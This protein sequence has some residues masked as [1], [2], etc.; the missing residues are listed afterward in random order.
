MRDTSCICTYSR[1]SSHSKD[2][3]WTVCRRAMVPRSSQRPIRRGKSESGCNAWPNKPAGAHSRARAKITT[4][5]IATP[6]RTG[7]LLQA[8]ARAHAMAV[9]TKGVGSLLGGTS[10]RLGF[11]FRNQ[12]HW[13]PAS[14]DRYSVCYCLLRRGGRCSR[15]QSFHRG[16]MKL[17]DPV[18]GR[19]SAVRRAYHFGCDK[20]LDALESLWS[21]HRRMILRVCS[22][23]GLN[24]SR[25][26]IKNNKFRARH[27]FLLL[28]GRSRCRL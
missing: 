15:L 8:P 9:M 11:L 20:S 24:V 12:K 22:L 3:S 14:R 1:P 2:T 17:G 27:G 19:C 28:L 6:G 4:L 21:D 23:E 5:R 16:E 25:R 18:E 13:F 10:K 7:S 26:G